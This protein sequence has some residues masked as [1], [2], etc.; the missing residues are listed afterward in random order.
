MSDEAHEVK[1]AY[2]RPETPRLTRVVLDVPPALREAYTRA[3]QVIVAPHADGP[4]YLALASA[5]GES[6]GF[7]LL[8]GEAAQARLG[9]EEGQSAQITAPTGRG[10]PLDA[11]KGRDVHFF[12]VGSAL[13]PIRAAIVTMLRTPD[14]YG[15]MSL[16]VGA[17]TEADFPF[18]DDLAAWQAAGIDVQKSISK[19]WV[20]TRFTERGIDA[21]AAA[22][23]VCGMRPMMDAVSEALVAAGMPADRIGRNW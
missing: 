11:A 16:Y 15:A 14:A 20:Q 18:A 22:A 6:E 23:F 19:P 1:V 3:G 5:P 21:S 10:F 12:A 8:L 4:T 9:W 7:M 13:A 2:A 17:H